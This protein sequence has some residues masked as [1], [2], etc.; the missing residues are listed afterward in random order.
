MA[1]QVERRTGLLQAIRRNFS[2]YWQRRAGL[3]ELGTIDAGELNRI[4]QDSGLSMADLI[5]V[6]KRGAD[7]TALL[8]RRLLDL[9]IERNRI[10]A[11]VLRDLQRCCSAC[12]SKAQCEHELE[13]QPKNAA[14]PRYCPNQDT[15]AVLTATKCH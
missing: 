11:A 8:D 1:M 4:A 6:A 5:A 7:S 2:R 14:W 9:G 12:D 13:D 10:D 15:L 3:D